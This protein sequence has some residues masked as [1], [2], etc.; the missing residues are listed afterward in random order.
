[1]VRVMIVDDETIV[2]KGI[3]RNTDWASLGCEVVAEAEN[4]EEGLRKAFETMPELVISDI[5]MPHMDGLA[6]T[7]KLREMNR[8]IKVI[9]LTAYGEFSYAQQ[10]VKLQ[11]ADYIL[12]PFG[13]GELEQVIRRVLKDRDETEDTA[14]R[15]D[16]ILPLQSVT[17]GMSRYVSEAVRCIEAH[18]KEEDMG[19]GVIAEALGVSE[20][21]LSRLFKKETGLSITAY[22]TRFRMRKAM[23]MLGDLH[24]KVYEAAEQCGY[25]DIAYFSATFKKL[26]GMNPSEYAGGTPTG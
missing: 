21:H 10:A 4:G 22:L 14:A 15:E 16:R 3:L 24:Y 6:M 17:E 20:G 7:E 25:R 8:D 9:F 23:Q 1:M 11:A 5:R 19:V 12:K 13:D 2:R 26:T 18:Y